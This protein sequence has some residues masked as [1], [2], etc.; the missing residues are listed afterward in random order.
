MQLKGT[1]VITVTDEDGG[2]LDQSTVDRTI[3][4]AFTEEETKTAP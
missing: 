1:T 4:V 2:D 3:T